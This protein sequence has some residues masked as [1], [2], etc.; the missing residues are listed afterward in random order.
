MTVVRTEVKTQLASVR[1]KI[2]SLVHNHTYNGKKKK[3]KNWKNF[4]QN[5]Y[6]DCLKGWDCG[7]FFFSFLLF[8]G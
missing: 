5:S 1:D 8:K 4:H 6:S 7:I 2:L 3:F